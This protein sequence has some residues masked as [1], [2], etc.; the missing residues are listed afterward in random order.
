MN[1]NVPIQSAVSFLLSS[2]PTLSKETVPLTGANGRVLAEN[3]LAA[4]D[5]PPFHRSAYDG[6]ALHSSGTLSACGK[7]PVH[8]RIT[9]TIAAGDFCQEPLEK[10]CAVRIMTG[11]PLPEGA[12][13]VINYERVTWTDQVL[14]LKD[15]LRPWENVDQKG[16]EIR[17]KTPL[18]EK[19]D[20]LAPIHSGLLASQGIDRV[21]VYRRP[22]AAVLSTGSELL[23]PGSPLSAGKIY[24]SSLYVLRALLEQESCCVEDCLHAADDEETISKA[25]LAL[26]GKNDLILTTGGASVG[27]KDYICSALKRAGAKILFSHVNMKP[28]SCCYGAKLKESL[29]ISLSGNPGAALTAWYLIA[30]PVVRKLSGRRCYT[31]PESM[32]PLSDSCRKTCPCPRILKGHTQAEGGTLR[33][34][35]HDGQRNGMQTSFLRMNALAILPPSD[36]PL[37]AGTMVRVLAVQ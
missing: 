4:I 2:A 16:D 20:L 14:T 9:G 25:I 28:G 21:T 3:I 30:L 15:P 32:L 37:P 36:E 17:S 11:A 7:A 27:D 35:A 5:L 1:K 22:R 23:E 29:I 18:L 10:G 6:F 8:F 13:C 33:F 19:G 24:N 34:V 26:A 12:D 31:L